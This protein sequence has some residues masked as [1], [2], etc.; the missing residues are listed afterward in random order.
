MLF[1]YGKD[2][3]KSQNP[4][5]FKNIKLVLKSFNKFNLAYPISLLK[6]IA[7]LKA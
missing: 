4:K 6:P 5:A 7:S 3:I 1:R 2:K